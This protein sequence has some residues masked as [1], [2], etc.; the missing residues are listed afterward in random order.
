MGWT[1][2]IPR[3]RTLGARAPEA[4]RLHFECGLAAGAIADRLGIDAEA[5]AEELALAVRRQRHERATGPARNRPRSRREQ[6]ALSEWDRAPDDV[7]DAA[8]G[9]APP[10]APPRAGEAIAPAEPTEWEGPV[11]PHGRR[12]DGSI[13]RR[14]KARPRRMARPKK[15]TDRNVKLTAADRDEIRRLA[16]EGWATRRLARHFH[17][18]VKTIRRLLNGQRW[19]SDR[20]APLVKP[21]TPPI[22]LR[23]RESPPGPSPPTYARRGPSIGAKLTPEQ[24]AE[25]RELSAQGWGSIRLGKRYGVN[26]GTIR[27]MLNGQS[28]AD[29][30]GAPLPPPRKVKPVQWD[31]DPKDPMHRDP[32]TVAGDVAMLLRVEASAAIRLP[33]IAADPVEWARA[34]GEG[35][36]G[37]PVLELDEAEIARLYVAEGLSLRS[38]AGRLGV[39]AKTVGQRLRALGVALR[40]SRP[41]RR[42]DE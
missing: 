38:I 11:S 40:P 32:E 4:R 29:D 17:V 20:K 6:A 21:S 13:I 15:D 37:Q 12:E 39:S 8:A 18:S 36:L 27:R 35:K 33:A 3:R 26:P 34:A 10:P 23:P 42:P 16:K 14:G 7:A 24:R 28:F 41:P 25:A 30:P 1:V 31:R 2:L 9:N 19:G 5:V 22:G